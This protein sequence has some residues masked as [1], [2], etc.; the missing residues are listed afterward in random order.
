MILLP[1]KFRIVL[2]VFVILAIGSSYLLFQDTKEKSDYKQVTGSVFYFSDKYG[3]LPS[4]DLGKYRYLQI[5]GYPYVFEIYFDGV[6]NKLNELKLGDLVT[7]YYYETGNTHKESINRFLQFIDKEGMEIYKR[8]SVMPTLGAV[9][10]GLCVA[11][12][13]LSYVL[14][15]KGK[16]PY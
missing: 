16:M 3:T 4:R 11:F 15:R 14:Y 5:E 1:F 8:N 9:L 12:S 7:A 2:T 13:I 10:I 6:D